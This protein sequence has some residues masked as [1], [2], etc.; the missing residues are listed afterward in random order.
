[1]SRECPTSAVCELEGCAQPYGPPPGTAVARER[2]P[3]DL[4]Y[5]PGRIM[6]RLMALTDAGE[7]VVKR[8]PTP[9]AT[10]PPPPP[11]LA[12]EVLRVMSSGPQPLP[13][14]PPALVGEIRILPIAGGW[15]IYVGEAPVAVA[16]TAAA[17]GA[18]VAELVQG[19]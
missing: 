5:K 7:R 18:R 14:V 19:K 6:R 3:I 16:T 12:E 2:Q 15:V 9:F 11:P 13:P 10:T 8:G 4:D 17:L 1:M